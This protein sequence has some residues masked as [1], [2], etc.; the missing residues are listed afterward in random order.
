MERMTI[1]AMHMFL[2]DGAVANG[3]PL[4]NEE[5]DNHNEKAA[6]ENSMVGSM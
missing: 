6:G 3:D 1:T 5:D 2:E 4:D